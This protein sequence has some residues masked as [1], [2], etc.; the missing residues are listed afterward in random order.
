M[1]GR[2]QQTAS[3]LA[4]L[5]ADVYLPRI[6]IH[7][8]P[9]EYRRSHVARVALFPGYLFARLDDE[10]RAR[11]SQSVLGTVPR[12]VDFGDGPIVVPEALITELQSREETGLELPA[13]P[14]LETFG[15]GEIVRVTAGPFRGFEA[16]YSRDSGHRVI[17][18]LQLLAAFREVEV[19]RSSLDRAN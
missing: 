6:K 15:V 1:V 4:T 3:R 11:A 19:D 7:T 2:E 10:V 8:R 12:W 13:E 5:G 14:E 9:T 17:V 18:L 16:I